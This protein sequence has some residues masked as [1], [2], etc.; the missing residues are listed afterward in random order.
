MPRLFKN[1]EGEIFDSIEDTIRVGNATGEIGVGD[2]ISVGCFVCF[3][4]DFTNAKKVTRSP[5]NI[6]NG[7][8]QKNNDVI[9]LKI[10]Y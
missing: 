8:K 7:V 5:I 1:I 6:V 9:T 3:L 2:Y 4:Q 10:T